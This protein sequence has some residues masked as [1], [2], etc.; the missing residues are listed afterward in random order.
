AH[1]LQGLLD[2]L[3][4][5]EQGVGGD[6]RDLELLAVDVRGVEGAGDDRVAEPNA[7]V[8]DEDE[9]G[10]GDQLGDLVLRL[11]AERAVQ[12]TLTGVGR[13]QS[14][15]VAGLVAHRALLRV[16]LILTVRYTLTSRLSRHP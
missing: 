4:A 5:G 3:Q 7:G 11:Q 9:P 16:R 1:P 13:R 12:R 14:V 10:A 2:R 15:R 6:V 8:A